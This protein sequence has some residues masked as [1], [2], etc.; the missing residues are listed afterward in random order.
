MTGYS[1]TVRRR[2]LSA[3]LRQARQQANL[4]ADVVARQLGWQA[5]KVTRIERNEWRLPSVSDVT[6]L[7]DVYGI[8]DEAVRQAL[9]RLAREARQRGWWEEFGDV[10]GGTLAEF[11]AEATSIRTFEALLVPGLLQ[12][13][14]YAAA[15]FRGGMVVDEAIIARRV[16]ARLARQQILERANPPTLWVVIDEAALR[17]HVGGPA[18]MRDQIHHLVEV[19]ARPNI[20]I[21]VLPDAAGAHAAMTGPFAIL[22]YATLE[23]ADLVYIETGA[24][25]DLYL[26]TTQEV[27]RYRLKYDHVCASALSADA[28]VAYLQDLVE[29]LK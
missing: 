23:D 10:L 20:A 24:T 21:Q 9:I 14:E 3:A 16:Q 25:G 7:M 22:S 17:K 13:A 18:V 29:Q 26:E 12:T 15:V 27:E 19:A 11:E 8:T 6:D 5:S 2:R 1:P 4:R 28:S